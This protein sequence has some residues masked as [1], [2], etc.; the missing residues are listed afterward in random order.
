MKLL[1]DRG[2]DVNAKNSNNETPLF[3]LATLTR[4]KPNEKEAMLLLI[5]HKADVNVKDAHSGKTPLGYA[6]ENQNAEAAEVL[7][8]HGAQ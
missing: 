3:R 7:K 5:T 2:A 4:L 1:I 8:A 6:L